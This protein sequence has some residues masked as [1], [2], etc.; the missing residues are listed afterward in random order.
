MEIH[1]DI[2]I[3]LHAVSNTAF[4]P[5][6]GCIWGLG[7]FVDLDI[8]IDDYCHVDCGT[9]IYLRSRIGGKKISARLLV[10]KN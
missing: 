7:H 5:S 9:V 4:E 3:E 8:Y 1:S 6:K 10:D 2:I